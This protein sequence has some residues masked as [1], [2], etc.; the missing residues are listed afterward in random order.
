VAVYERLKRLGMDLVTITDYDSIDAVEE[1]RS[2]PD[3]FLS[4]EVSC[5]LPSGSV[6]HVGVYDIGER[7]HVELQRRRDDFDSMAT[8]LAE[9]DS[10]LERQPHLFQPDRTARSTRF[11]LVRNGFSSSGN[12]QGAHAGPG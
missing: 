4:E 11:R 6:L 2:R 12:A 9:R 1:L 3:F 10:L 7:D 8:Y 5:R